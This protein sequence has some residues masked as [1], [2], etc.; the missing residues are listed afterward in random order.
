MPT[1][2][3]T[4]R[5]FLLAV[6]AVTSM[7]SVTALPPL[8]LRH[9]EIQGRDRRA[10]TG[11]PD[12]PSVHWKLSPSTVLRLSKR[13]EDS[14]QWLDGWNLVQRL[15][16]HGGTKLPFRRTGLVLL[17]MDTLQRPVSEI[18]SCGNKRNPKKKILFFQM[19]TI[20]S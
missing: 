3:I 5:L 9:L 6:I 14:A 8:F 4:F 20:I 16:R 12:S 13:Q 10:D 7:N 2:S 11:I 1:T 15:R 17:D 19:R 18:T